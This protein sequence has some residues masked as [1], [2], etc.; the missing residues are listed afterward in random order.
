MDF[1]VAV[2]AIVACGD[3]GATNNSLHSLALGRRREGGGDEVDVVMVDVDEDAE[4]ATVWKTWMGRASKN[5]WAMMKGVVEL[6]DDVST[7]K[8]STNGSQPT[9]RDKLHVLA[10][11]Y[12]LPWS[13]LAH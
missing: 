5:S 7:Y 9:F 12:L 4:E 3:V 11:Y 10:P 2:A 13:V 1:S 8:D 6:S